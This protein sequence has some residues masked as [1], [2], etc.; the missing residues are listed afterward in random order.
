VNNPVC[1]H[2][3]MDFVKIYFVC[4]IGK[5]QYFSVVTQ[6][7]WMSVGV[8]V[9]F[10]VIAAPPFTERSDRAY[11]HTVIGIDTLDLLKLRP[12]VQLY[13]KDEETNVRRFRR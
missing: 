5:H 2:Q 1:V 4:H 11:I 10:S 3:R 12:E 6:P 8:A 9:R 7:L 13:R